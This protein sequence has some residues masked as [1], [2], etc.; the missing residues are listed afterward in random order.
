[1][2][3]TEPSAS[4]VEQALALLRDA[5][6]EA[7]ATVRSYDTKAQI[8]GVGYIFALGIVNNLKRFL[9]RVDDVGPEAVVLTWAIVIFPVLLFG[10]VLYPSRR[11]APVVD[12]G[13][14]KPIRSVLYVSN[15]APRTL[16]Q[17]RTNALAAD[18]L[19]ELSFELLKVSGLR[20]L[21]RRRFLRALFAA[22]VSFVFLFVVQLLRFYPGLDAGGA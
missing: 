14:P 3:T 21:K 2:E 17:I 9:P 15:E 13:A 20:D 6:A 8:V 10:Y 1:M 16:D 19:D 22:L 4:Q 5:L 18:P 7:Q 12:R 11:I